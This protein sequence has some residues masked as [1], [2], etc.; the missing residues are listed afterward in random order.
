MAILGDT[1]ELNNKIEAEEVNVEFIDDILIYTAAF[2]DKSTMEL[3]DKNYVEYIEWEIKDGD[4]NTLSTLAATY[5]N[6]DMLKH[7]MNNKY[8]EGDYTKVYYNYIGYYY[9][10]F[11]AAMNSKDI[12]KSNYMLDIIIEKQEDKLV[13][14]EDSH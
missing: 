13:I 14:D 10:T 2:G 7:L 11:S 9:H 4:G 8:F 1:N 6:L 3:L 5:N 12:H